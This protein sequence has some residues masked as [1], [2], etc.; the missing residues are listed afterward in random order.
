MVQELLS[1]GMIWGGREEEKE[2]EKIWRIKGRKEEKEEEKDWRIY[3][4]KEE[5]EE[6]KIWRIT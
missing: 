5:K 1:K 2:E 6:E 4:R 3:G